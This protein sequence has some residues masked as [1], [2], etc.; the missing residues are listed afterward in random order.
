MSFADRFLWGLL[1]LGAAAALLV[2]FPHGFG[3]APA[4]P[5]PAETATAAA[6]APVEG[7][8]DL[9]AGTPARH[10]DAVPDPAMAERITAVRVFSGILAGIAL[11]I[12][13][14]AWRKRQYLRP[15]PCDVCDREARPLKEYRLGE[16]RN[17]STHTVCWIC[18]TQKYLFLLLF[19]ALVIGAAIGIDTLKVH[20]PS[21]GVSVTSPDRYD[22]F[23]TIG[24]F[25]WL[26]GGV[27]LYQLVRLVKPA[28]ILE[29]RAAAAE[30]DPA[31]SESELFVRL[32]GLDAE[33]LAW[34]HDDGTAELDRLNRE[35]RQIGE[36]L[37][38]QGGKARM[39]AVHRA[40]GLGRPI[41][42][43]WDG[44]GQ[45]RG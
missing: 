34:T 25:V 42:S 38:H 15:G 3:T 18:E 10:G 31:E 14:K 27:A 19:A 35:A 13:F 9:A 26:V 17:Q 5:R 1:F 45:W 20:F 33:L 22:S 28:G 30:T 40:L 6:P 8:P 12:F 32:Q 41:E 29:R 16:G 43:A 2:L 37:H 7:Q 39:L 11:L 21:S 24:F 4:A 36:I 44:I 23:V